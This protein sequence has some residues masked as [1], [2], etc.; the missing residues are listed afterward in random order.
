MPAFGRGA[1]ISFARHYNRCTISV[2][3]TPYRL[4]CP[5]AKEHAGCFLADD[6]VQMRAFFAARPD[7]AATPTPALPCARTR[8]RHLAASWAKDESGRFGLN[9]FKLLGARFAIET[10]LAEGGI[11]SGDTVVCAS[12]GN[13]GRAV[14]RAARDAGC[15]SRGLHGAPMPRR[16]ASMPSPARAP[17]SFASMVRTTMRCGCCRGMRRRTAGP[18]SRTPRGRDTNASR[19]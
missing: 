15:A 3:H 2:L 18:S 10:L 4:F 19:S 12:E 9:A 7:L 1:E 16:R 6:Y 11:H 17:R 5:G 14:A 13:H 8:S